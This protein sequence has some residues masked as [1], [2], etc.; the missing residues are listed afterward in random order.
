MFGGGVGTTPAGPGRPTP[1]GPPCTSQNAAS[2]PLGRDSMTFPV[3]LVKTLK[4]RRK[5][6][7][8]P[9][10]VPISQN[11]VEKSPL[12][13][14]GIPYSVAFSHKELMVPFGARLVLYCQNDEV[15]PDV[16]PWFWTRKG[17]Q[18]P[19]R[20]TAASCLLL[21][22]PHLAQRGILNALV[23]RRFA[24]DYD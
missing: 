6:R 5:V 8:R 3:K 4:C 10:I 12:G 1:G 16:H 14:L 15:S 22:A 23:F 24:P 17:R 13:I 9:A 11:G 7:K 19:P 18:I 20:S 2:G 21:T